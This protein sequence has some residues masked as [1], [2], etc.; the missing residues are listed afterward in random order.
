FFGLAAGTSRLWQHLAGATAEMDA[1]RDTVALSDLT[2]AARVRGWLAG[3]EPPPP[4]GR[5]REHRWV[6]GRFP[7]VGAYLSLVR[8]FVSLRFLGFAR[9]YAW[10][11]SL[12][13]TVQAGRG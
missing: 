9:T 1:T 7:S 6:W 4:P 5:G 13:R 8:A 12:P 11:Q 2:E 3:P 10:A